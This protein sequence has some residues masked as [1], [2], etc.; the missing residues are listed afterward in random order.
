[1]SST[2]TDR[3]TALFLVAL[4]T[5]G[6][7]LAGSCG[8]RSRAGGRRGSTT[9]AHRPSQP[10]ARTARLA[11]LVAR[12]LRPPRCCGRGS[13]A[14]VLLLLYV[15]PLWRPHVSGLVPPIAL[16][17]ACY[18]PP[19]RA[20]VAVAAVGVVAQLWFLAASDDAFYF[21]PGGYDDDT[22]R[23]RGRARRAARPAPGP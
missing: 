9:G 19:M 21:A 1:M 3:D 20:A 17:I 14:T 8:L 18:R 23:P 15:H 12:P 5:L 7:G 11:P 2:F 6:A 13:S 16:L 10:D 4:L 22:G